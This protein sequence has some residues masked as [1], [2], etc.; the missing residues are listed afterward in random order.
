M[1]G[2]HGTWSAN[3]SMTECDVLLAVGA[4]FDDRVTGRL[5]GFSQNSRKIHI[6]IDPSCI[7]KNVD[8]EVPIVGD[9]K[10]VLPA[11]DK[12]ATPPQIDEWWDTIRTWQKE[13]S[14]VVTEREEK[15]YPQTRSGAIH[16]V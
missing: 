12:L 9:V 2:M 15:I 10:H 4:R 1:L 5:D 8:V 3:M 11:I 13:H 6:D 16:E 7:G 14:P